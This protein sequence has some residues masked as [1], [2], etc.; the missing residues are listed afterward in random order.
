MDN[1]AYFAAMKKAGR[2]QFGFKPVPVPPKVDNRAS[3][4][5]QVRRPIPNMRQLGKPLSAPPLKQN[6]KFPPGFGLV[7]PGVLVGKKK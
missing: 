1:A 4:V 3:L 2:K 6:D 5:Q 7:R